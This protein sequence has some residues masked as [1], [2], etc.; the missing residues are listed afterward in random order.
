MGDQICKFLGAWIAR[1]AGPE[2]YFRQYCP[3]GQTGLR[4]PETLQTEVKT[5]DDVIRAME[6]WNADLAW[7]I[8]QQQR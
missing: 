5:V 6:T 3:Q 8:F 7:F 4:I 2:Y 1:Y